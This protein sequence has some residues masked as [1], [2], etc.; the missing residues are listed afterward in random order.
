MNFLFWPFLWFAGAT[1]EKK[2]PKMLEKY[3]QR[4]FWYV[5]RFF[6]YFRGVLGVF[7]GGPEFRAQ[8]GTFSVVCMGIPGAAILGFST[9]NRNRRYYL[10]SAPV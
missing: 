7:S 5:G 10:S 9:S 1:P 6:W 2:I 8:G 4:A 3:P